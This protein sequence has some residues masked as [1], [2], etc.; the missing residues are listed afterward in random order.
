MDFVEIFLM[1]TLAVRSPAEFLL[2]T[3][4]SEG[5]I[6]KRGAKLTTGGEPALSPLEELTGTKTS[7]KQTS[8]TQTL[9][10]TILE[11]I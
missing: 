1:V 10:K 4:S 8:M 6:D 3:I 2:N 5:V 9:F 11:L 7:L